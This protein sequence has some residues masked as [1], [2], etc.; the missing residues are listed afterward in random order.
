M[1]PYTSQGERQYIIMIHRPGRQGWFIGK[2]VIK[3][4]FWKMTFE[5]FCHA[6]N[7]IEKNRSQQ[8]KTS[9]SRDKSS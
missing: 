2:A 8:S 3:V 9:F 7:L 6:L 5:K 1:I 4:D